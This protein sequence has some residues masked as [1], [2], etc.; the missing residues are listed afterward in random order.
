MLQAEATWGGKGLIWPYTPQSITEGSQ[1][2]NSRQESEVGLKV[3]AVE[4]PS[5]P[6]LS[7][8]LG[9]PV[10]L[11]TLGPPTVSC[12]LSGQSLIKKMHSRVCPQ[13]VWWEHFLN[14]RLTLPKLLSLV[15]SWQPNWPR[16]VAYK[17]VPWHCSNTFSTQFTEA[18]ILQNRSNHI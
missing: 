18:F 14:L 7:P 10:F 4:D 12:T 5:S 15:S 1:G 9:Q 13:P 17:A 8:W 16:C 6:A 11:Y 3:E 2:E